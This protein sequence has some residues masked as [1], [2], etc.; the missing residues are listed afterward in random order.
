[1]EGPVVV[2]PRADAV[3][4]L[5]EHPLARTRAWIKSGALRNAVVVAG[6]AGALLACSRNSV[7]LGAGVNDAPIFGT[8]DAGD[9]GSAQAD[10]G[11]CPATACPA[12]WATC[13][14]V[15][16]TLPVYACSIDL[17]TDRNHCGSCDVV[18]KDPSAAYNVRMA[19]ASG[20]C[21]AFCYE[22]Y[23]DCNGVTDDGCEANTKEDPNN[24]GACGTACAPGV[25]CV[26]GKCGCPP[27]MTVCDGRCVDVSKDDLNCGACHHS[28]LEDQPTDAGSTP[29]HMF[30]GCSE[31]QCKDLRCMQVGEF[32]ADCN[33]DTALDGC[34][35]NLR[36]D[37]KNCGACGNACE[38]GQRCIDDG[39]VVQCQCQQGRSYCP[40]RAG[41]LE[42]CFDLENDPRNC[43][44]CG[45]VCPYVA[46]AAPVCD[47][48]RCKHECLPGTADCNGREDDGCEVELNKD[49]RNCGGCG[50]TCDVARGQPCVGGHCLMGDCDDPVAR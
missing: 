1:M 13:P 36:S 21:Q 27:G 49:P 16:G 2:S 22:G 28:C 24:C 14:G 48:G 37:V 10:A 15:D 43:G 38:P 3:G 12:P 30:Y 47:R 5:S 20:Q 17:S 26:R 34:E 44:A 33:H 35:V 32:W 11:V 50:T 46:N 41:G 23:A 29:D 45:Y 18:C 7:T 8:A 40:A 19:C 9:G 6:V 25:A 31:G 39:A 4:G 42:G